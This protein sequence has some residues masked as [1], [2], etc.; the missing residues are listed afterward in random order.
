MMFCGRCGTPIWPPIRKDHCEIVDYLCKRCGWRA[1]ENLSKEEL[2][3]FLWEANIKDGY[4]MEEYSQSKDVD[5]YSSI[6]DTDLCNDCVR[7]YDYDNYCYNC[8]VVTLRVETATEY[9]PS[10]N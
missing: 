10:Q 1:S 8:K 6:I 7:D 5:N 2:E 3:Y 9:S 4:S